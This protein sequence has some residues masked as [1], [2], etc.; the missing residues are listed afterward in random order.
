MGESSI[1]K[2]VFKFFSLEKCYIYNIFTILSQ[3]IQGDRFLWVFNLNPSLKL[4][5]CPPIIVC[6]NLTHMI[7]YE[8]VVDVTFLF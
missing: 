7:C 2:L 1:L 5:S 3:Q 4:L 6:N 8:N